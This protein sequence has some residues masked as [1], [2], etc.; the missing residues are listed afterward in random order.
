[1]QPSSEY[2][3]FPFI[4]T[5]IWNDIYDCDK[6]K[7]FMWAQIVSFWLF[8]AA[9]VPTQYPGT[10]LL[11]DKKKKKKVNHLSYGWRA[12]EGKSLRIP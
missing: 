1:M 12:G 7:S 4:N 3:E 8:I 6:S 10:S 2:P 5:D 11:D 9:I